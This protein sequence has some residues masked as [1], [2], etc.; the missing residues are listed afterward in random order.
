MEQS[1]IIASLKQIHEKVSAL[2]KAIEPEKCSC[3]ED[4][5]SKQ[6]QNCF[7]YTYNVVCEFCNG[8]PY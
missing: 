1:T 8:D 5:P 6:C 2:L 3:H 7:A 4:K